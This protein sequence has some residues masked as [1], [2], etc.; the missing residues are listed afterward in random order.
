MP[1]SLRGVFT[2]NEA[3]VSD[4]K[5]SS[6]LECE[7][8]LT[9]AEKLRSDLHK[10]AKLRNEME[11]EWSRISHEFQVIHKYLFCHCI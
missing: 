9:C 3:T 10:A 6:C 5:S 8:N 7:K 11:E 1:Y 4:E 2:Q